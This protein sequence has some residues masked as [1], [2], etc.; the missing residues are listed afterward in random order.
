MLYL[1]R[2]AQAAVSAHTHRR[3]DIQTQKPMQITCRSKVHHSFP[4]LILTYST[5]QSLSNGAPRAWIG[6]NQICSRMLY[7]LTVPL[8]PCY[9]MPW[10]YKVQNDVE[11]PSSKRKRMDNTRRLNDLVL[12][13]INCHIL[14]RRSYFLYNKEKER[15]KTKKFI[16]TL[17]SPV[18]VKANKTREIQI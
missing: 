11:N 17:F 9:V 16:K 15:D 13:K 6:D 10:R 14:P 8:P 18:I 5:H 7:H 12:Y 4:L 1:I 3:Y 2:A